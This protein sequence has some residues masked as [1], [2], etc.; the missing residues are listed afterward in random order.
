MRGFIMPED[1]V[2]SNNLESNLIKRFSN[3]K[4]YY[5]TNN[6]KYKRDRL[7]ADFSKDKAKEFIKE[8]ITVGGK[9][10]L[11]DFNFI[12][13]YRE[14]G[15]HQHSVA[16]YFLGIYFKDLV[17][18]KI[19]NKIKAKYKQSY[20]DKTFSYIWFLAS[21]FHDTASVIESEK[22][23]NIRRNNLDLDCYLDEYNIRY[24]VF[25]HKCLNDELY[26]YPQN[27]VKNYFKYKLNKRRE[28]DHGILGG[29]LL[30]DKLIKNYKDA[31][32]DYNGL[33]TNDY[34]DFIINGLHWSSTH[35]NYYAYAAHAIIEHNMWFAPNEE[36]KKIYKKYGLNTLISPPA[37][38]ICIKENPLL[39]YLGLFDTIE[40][41]KPFL[42]K[43]NAE[44]NEILKN[45]DISVNNGNI[46][47]SYTEKLKTYTE[48]YEKWIDNIYSLKNWLELK[49]SPKKQDVQNKHYPIE[50]IIN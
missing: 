32:E 4:N 11:F 41:L 43:G 45:I 48:E 14:K 26:T 13:E 17:E 7:L 33:S 9:E 1:K 39:F 40:P 22:Q 24:N 50:I 37:K 21:L 15:K 29:H 28:I 20:K 31:Y 35:H 16:L 34:D 10:K 19:K 36:Y 47:I 2:E 25:E 23:I 8:Y 27:I 38:K 12:Q 18:K 3:V 5:R 42:E 49:I 46:K 30:F 6:L 44:A